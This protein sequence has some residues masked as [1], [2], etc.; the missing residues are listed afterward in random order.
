MNV[1]ALRDL[2][3]FADDS[4]MFGRG[5]NDSASSYNPKARR[6][7]WASQMMEGPAG[8]MR[9]DFFA[10][11]PQQTQAAPYAAP[12]RMQPMQPRQMTT[13]RD[14]R[15]DNFLARLMGGANGR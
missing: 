8:G 7:Q 11:A 2:M 3:K 6:A 5:W 13:Q 12:E 4:E 15:I 1:N 14:P 10:E 9:P